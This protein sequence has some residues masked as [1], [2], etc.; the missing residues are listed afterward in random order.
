MHFI[1]V[2]RGLDRNAMLVRERLLLELST[3]ALVANS[4][5]IGG[6]SFKAILL[7]AFNCRVVPDEMLADWFGQDPWVP[8]WWR[9]PACIPEPSLQRHILRH[10]SD[11]AATKA[12]ELRKQLE[13]LDDETGP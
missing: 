8:A 6:S 10:I 5:S 11:E 13:A 7:R 2:N 9:E 1:V 4:F 3:D 12:W